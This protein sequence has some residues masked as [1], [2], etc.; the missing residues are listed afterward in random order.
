M[1]Q[2]LA[3]GDVFAVEGEAV[4]LLDVVY[5]PALQLL[6]EV[7]VG[8]VR[9]FRGGGC[10]DAGRQGFGWRGEHHFRLHSRLHSLAARWLFLDLAWSFSLLFLPDCK[11]GANA[12][13]TIL[14]PLLP[15]ILPLP[16]GLDLLGQDNF[17]A[18]RT[19]FRVDDLLIGDIAACP[20][21]LDPAQFVDQLPADSEL[22]VHDIQAI[23]V[24]AS[25]PLRLSLTMNSVLPRPISSPSR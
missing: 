13:G 1:D 16:F 21:A 12:T 17:L 11:A 15:D 9:E 10:L 2:S 23:Y 24:E 25:L 19:P 4:Q 7:D 5:S 8:V 18:F 20:A 14:L 22:L 6:L 3:H